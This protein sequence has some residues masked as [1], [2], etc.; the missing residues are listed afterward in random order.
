MKTI[1]PET[2]QKYGYRMFDCSLQEMYQ[3]SNDCYAVKKGLTPSE[4][5]NYVTFADVD[6]AVKKI[7]SFFIPVE[8]GDLPYIEWTLQESSRLLIKKI[9]FYRLEDQQL[10]QC[11]VERAWALGGHL[12]PRVEQHYYE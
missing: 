8:H 7:S 1:L 2:Y 9:W 5:F 6:T 12:D 4:K 10:Y 3:Y 11:A